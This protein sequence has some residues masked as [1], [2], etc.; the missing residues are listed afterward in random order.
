VHGL[1]QWAIQRERLAV[2][3]ILDLLSEP[4]LQRWK[5]FPGV[6]K[7]PGKRWG[8]RGKKNGEMG[9]KPCLLHFF[10]NYWDIKD[11]EKSREIMKTG[12]KHQP[13]GM[14]P[15]EMTNK[16]DDNLGPISRN[17]YPHCISNGQVFYPHLCWLNRYIAASE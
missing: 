2:P 7:K 10:K 13:C 17:P 3:E 9:F 15:T 16:L 6:S 4:L 12:L 11:L 1:Q 8:K 5:R 14:F